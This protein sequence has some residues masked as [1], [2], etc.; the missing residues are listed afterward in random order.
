[1]KT[2][3]SFLLS[4]FTLSCFAQKPWVSWHYQSGCRVFDPQGARL[5]DFPGQI[6]LFF[7]NG[8]FV[9]RQPNGLSLYTKEKEV[10]WTLPGYYHHMLSL[11]PDKTKILALLSEVITVD[12]VRH[13]YDFFQ[14]ISLD[15]KVLHQG[16]SKDYLEHLKLPTLKRPT[17]G[18][19][20]VDMP[21]DFEATHFNS[22]YEIPP[23]KNPK[24][25]PALRKMGK[26]VLSGLG[27]GMFVVSEDLKTVALFNPLKHSE[28]A[29][30]HDIQVMESGQ[31]LL[32]NNQ[33]SD[34][35]AQVN[36]S[37]ID[38]LDPVSDKLIYRF[39]AQPQGS[40]YSPYCGS[41]QELDATTLLF[42]DL[43]NGTYILDK[44]KKSFLKI[45]RSTHDP[46]DKFHLVQEVKRVDLKAFLAHW[47]K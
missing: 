22:I 2:L 7:D 15:G 36:Y 34:K 23:V 1:M 4:L 30:V 41:V 16:H 5:R 8:S 33:P 10:L 28:Q 17:M 42:T 3:L 12:G 35:R 39:T 46:G 25:H 45:L 21:S 37:S 31:V 13:K 11:S 26:Y 20:A 9:S 6:C 40:F 14:V 29:N 43:L 19:L 24:A 32:F 27:H 44:N 47:L 18:P 38:I